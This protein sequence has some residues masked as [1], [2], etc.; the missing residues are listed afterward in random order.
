MD[1]AP[2]PD[3]V[4][5]FPALLRG[6]RNT[7]A[8]A[9]RHAHRAAGFEDLPRNGAFVLGAIAR[10]GSSIGEI[11]PWL[12]V[13]KQAAGQLVDTLVLRGYLERTPDPEDRRRLTLSLTERGAAAAAAGR[14]AVEE[15][16]ALLVER[17]G[18]DTVARA[19]QALG[20]LTDLGFEDGGAGG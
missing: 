12:R 16:D 7:Y 3:D 2:E 1:R 14:A 13:S 11:I 9:I 18:A 5:T 17:V 4:I 10:T 20:V 8:G 19:R 15:V 6:A